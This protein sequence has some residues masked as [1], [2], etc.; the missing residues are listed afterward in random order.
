MRATSLL[1]LLALVAVTGCTDKAEPVGAKPVG[2][3]QAEPVGNAISASTFET[4]SKYSANGQA[5]G[6]QCT[7]TYSGDSTDADGDTVPDIMNSVV[8]SNCTDAESG[9]VVNASFSVVDDLV[10]QVNPALYPFNATFDG[11]FDV[12]ATNAAEGVTVSI[13]ADQTFSVHQGATS[14]GGSDS[15]S[16]ATDFTAPDASFSAD[17]S[18]AW[19][20]TYTQDTGTG[21][22]FGD[23]LMSL[24]GGWN[25]EMEA[26][27]G[28]DS[29]T[30]YANATV[31]AQAPGLVLDDACPSHVVGG[32]LTATY[33]AGAAE[34]D[35]SATVSATLT[36]TFSACDS[37]TTA[38]TETVNP[39]PSS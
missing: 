38:Y 21:S 32:V 29:A 16:V 5:F 28:D 17:E 18:Y 1:S 2:A 31:A 36:V 14:F 12:S 15:A 39:G 30:V 33:D 13:A 26:H 19:D 25:V 24:T 20:S 11:H 34:N 37:W 22:V 3:A 23:G 8:V 10:E 35:D 7:E 9:G 4:A 6:G 27:Q